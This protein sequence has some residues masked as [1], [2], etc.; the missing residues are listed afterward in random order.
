[1]KSNEIKIC[2]FKEEEIQ[3]V[4]HTTKSAPHT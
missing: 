2:N 3:N 1:M 4:D